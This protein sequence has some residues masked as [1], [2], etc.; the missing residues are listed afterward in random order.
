ME[1]NINGL[2]MNF[3]NYL[4]NSLEHFKKA[5]VERDSEDWNEWIKLS[6]DVFVLCKVEE[7][8]ENKIDLEYGVL[9]KGGDYEW[10]EVIVL[11]KTKLLAAQ[12]G[13]DIKEIVSN[14]HISFAFVKFEHP[15]I[16]GDD[17]VALD[18][19]FGEVICNSQFPKGTEVCAPVKCCTFK[20]KS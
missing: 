2:V 19:V 17:T 20:L 11:P 5:G 8:F 1:I 9:P 3:Y 16:K 6:Y 13:G 7:F 18:Y 4:K 15:L 14:E 10:I 12:P